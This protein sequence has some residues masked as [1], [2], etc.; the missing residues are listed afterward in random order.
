MV[1]GIAVAG[2]IGFTFVMGAAYAGTMRA[3]AVYFDPEQHSVF[4]GSSH[5]PPT[6]DYLT[7]EARER[8]RAGEDD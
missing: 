8:S 2:L 1:L 7:P 5:R 3:L 4:L 6:D